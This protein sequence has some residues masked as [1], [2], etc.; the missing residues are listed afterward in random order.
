MKHSVNWVFAQLTPQVSLSLHS[1]SLTPL[2]LTII[3]FLLLF[4]CFPSFAYLQLSCSL[5]FLSPANYF[6]SH[7]SVS[8]HLLAGWWAAGNTTAQIVPICCEVSF[9]AKCS[10][11]NFQFLHSQLDF[12][13]K[14]NGVV[15]KQEDDFRMQDEIF[16]A[17]CLGFTRSG[18]EMEQHSEQEGKSSWNCAEVE[19]SGSYHVP[20]SAKIHF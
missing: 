20:T 7:F 15:R 10:V 11:Q 13:E 2:V 5:F 12:P 18:C 16:F 6:R 17:Q 9:F 19:D 3:M 1:R 14:K 4:L 8:S